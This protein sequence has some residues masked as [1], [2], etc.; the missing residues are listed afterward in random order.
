LIL[1]RISHNP[2]AASPQALGLLR[3]TA[4]FDPQSIYNAIPVEMLALFQETGLASQTLATFRDEVCEKSELA[5]IS[6]PTGV[7]TFNVGPSS[8]KIRCYGNGTHSGNGRSH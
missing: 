4:H 6:R 3:Q 1:A 2:S 5:R 8:C 7:A